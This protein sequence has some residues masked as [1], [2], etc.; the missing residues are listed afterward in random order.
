MIDLFRIIKGREVK[1]LRRYFI[2]DMVNTKR[3]VAINSIYI[4]QIDSFKL[5]VN[6][7]IKDNY[8]NGRISGISFKK[9]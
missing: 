9:K 8:Q 4:Q 1:N 2:L 6:T 3:L 7:A 5:E